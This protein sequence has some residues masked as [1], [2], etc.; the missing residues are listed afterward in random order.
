LQI[1]SISDKGQVRT[2]NEDRCMTYAISNQLSVAIVAD[3]MGGH[4]AGDIA[5]QMAIDLL[6][7]HIAYLQDGLPIDSY[8][9]I[10][11]K[12]IYDVNQKIYEFSSVNPAY[13]GMG[14]TLVVVVANRDK[15][16]VAHIGDSRA[17]LLGKSEIAQL[18]TDHSL[19]SELIKSG[20]ISVDEAE[21]HP[22]KNI[23]TRAL[24]T[25]IEID[26]DLQF[27]E[28]KP[29]DVILICTDGLSGLVDPLDVL[30]IVQDASHLQV[31]SEYL[32]QKAL[33]AGGYDNI[34]LA[35]IANHD[36][37]GRGQ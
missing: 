16:I 28:W 32:V 8:A 20:Q 30:H 1:V 10:I 24:G 19:V 14:T 2:V 11:Q 35:L 17:Y 23:L 25:E 26:I 4:N 3:G 5:S 13:Q 31:A 34:T 37:N 18:T 12:A 29:Q 7:E 33:D 6:S 9:N 21:K 27:F 15:F 36:E 22:R